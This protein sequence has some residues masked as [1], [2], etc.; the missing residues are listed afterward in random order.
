MT[1]VIRKKI[2]DFFLQNKFL[3]RLRSFFYQKFFP[4]LIKTILIIITSICLILGGL[5]MFKPIYLE[6][7]S[8]QFRLYFFHSLKLDNQEFDRININ[9]NNRVSREEIIETLKNIQKNSSTKTTNQD[10]QIL[11]QKLIIEIK[12]LPWVHHALITRTMPNTLNITITEYEPFATWQY[13]G[14][15]FVIDK[16]GNKITVN[17]IEEFSNLV[18]LSGDE[19]NINVKSL[20]NLF[21]LDSEL[22]KNVYSATWIGKRRWDVRFENGT[23]IKLPEANLGEAWQRL[24]KLYKTPGITTGLKTID[25]RINNNVYLEY[26]DSMIKELKNI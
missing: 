22:S 6:K 18:T 10:E 19:A 2:S 12:K 3:R 9:G 13:A 20:F 5:K 24:I 4:A 25:L 11:L 23:L 1:N 26:N 17:N 15:K 8:H 16:D 7:I 14:K 21:T